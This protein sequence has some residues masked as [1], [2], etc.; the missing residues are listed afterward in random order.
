MMARYAK[1]SKASQPQPRPSVFGSEIT[2]CVL[3][4][5]VVNGPCRLREIA[6]LTEHP[7]SSVADVVQRLSRA[8]LVQT[9]RTFPERFFCFALNDNSAVYPELMSFLVVLHR[10]WPLTRRKANH[11]RGRLRA[12][13]LQR[14]Q[15][16]E[17]DRRSIRLRLLL[18]V[19]RAGRITVSELAGVLNT[20]Y[21]SAWRVAKVLTRDCI[22]TMHRDGRNRVVALDRRFVAGA[23]LERF[24]HAMTS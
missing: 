3:D 8:G 22:L 20:S 4:C 11:A 21:A 19:Y 12:A 10:R 13:V 17:I 1:V 23:E 14:P 2:E 5:L 24:L 16:A 15:V 9:I 7:V 6:K 18:A